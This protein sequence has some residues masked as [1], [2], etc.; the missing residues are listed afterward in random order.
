M[1]ILPSKLVS[2]RITVTFWMADEMEPLETIASHE[3]IINVFS[4]EDPHP[5]EMLWQNGEHEDG[6]FV[7]QQI[8][9]GLPGV[10]YTLECSA[11]TD[12]GKTIQKQC[13]LAI[14]P[15]SG[16]IPALFGDYFTTH[17]Y[18]IEAGEV[19]QNALADISGIIREM[20]FPL[21]KYQNALVSI[22]GTIRALLISYV[23]PPE[24]YQ[25][26]FDDLSGT[27]R[28]LLISYTCPPEFYQNAFNISS[29]TLEV[30]LISYVTPPDNYENAF[31]Q[32][33]GTLT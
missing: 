33:S 15:D 10:I 24:F 2:E 12:T 20:P 4:G 28:T 21:D 17:I 9:A 7:T 23:G 5:E 6:Q 16:L 22:E 13:R 27:L 11:V 14:L 31:V 29:G 19:Y 1:M 18:P 30:K 3:V 25:N 8:Q 26:A 32:I